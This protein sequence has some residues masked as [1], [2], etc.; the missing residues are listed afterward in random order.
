MLFFLFHVKTVNLTTTD[1]IET[2]LKPSF[3]CVSLTEQYVVITTAS[4][5][6]SGT[7]VLGRVNSIHGTL[8]KYNKA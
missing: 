3:T 6:K 5:T 7:R 8:N 1:A 4:D 2:Q